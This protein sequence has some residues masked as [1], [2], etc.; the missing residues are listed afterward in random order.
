MDTRQ[1]LLDDISARL[2]P[3]KDVLIG[4]KPGRRVP[5]TNYIEYENGDLEVEFSWEPLPSN[6]MVLHRWCQKTQEQMI[7]NRIRIP[8]EM[9]VVDKGKI[10]LEP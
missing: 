10:N 3:Y 6:A 9:L 7:L 2:E 4:T 1:Q 5:G 8:P